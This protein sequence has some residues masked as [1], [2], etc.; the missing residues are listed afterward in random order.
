LERLRPAR[1]ETDGGA[2]GH[3]V[4]IAVAVVGDSLIPGAAVAMVA[5]A[6]VITGLGEWCWGAEGT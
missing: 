2:D 6:V 3:A 5:L 4:A 1:R